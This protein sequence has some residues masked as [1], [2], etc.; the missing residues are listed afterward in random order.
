MPGAMLASHCEWLGSFWAFFQSLIGSWYPRAAAECFGG[1]PGR[2]ASSPNH[3][4]FLSLASWSLNSG[5]WSHTEYHPGAS[6]VGVGKQAELLRASTGL[7]EEEDGLPLQGLEELPLLGVLQE[8]RK[9]EVLREKKALF[10]GLSTLKEELHTQAQLYLGL[11]RVFKRVYNTLL[12]LIYSSCLSRCTEDMISS[13]TGENEGMERL[14][15]ISEL[16][17]TGN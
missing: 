16:T 10:Y 17:H 5:L 4:T 8:R 9:C 1:E 11:I 13:Y 3:T 12:C 7:T 15:G 14:S 2:R 6:S